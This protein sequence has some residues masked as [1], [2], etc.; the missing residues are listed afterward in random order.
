LHLAGDFARASGEHGTADLNEVAQVNELPKKLVVGFFAENVTLQV[1]LDPAA[2]ILDVRKRSLAHD[3]DRDHSPN[4]GDLFA[5][6]KLAGLECLRGLGV[7]VGSRPGQAWR[8]WLD[9][10]VAQAGELFSANKL[11][12]VQIKVGV[13]HDV[14]PIRC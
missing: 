14:A 3:P 6:G 5:F 7:G 8:V 13:F 2:A 4:Q 1:H 9:A 11:L 12:L 10:K